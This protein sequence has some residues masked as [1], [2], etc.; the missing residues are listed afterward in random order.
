MPNPTQ[1]HVDLGFDLP[2]AGTI[3]LAVYD[4]AGRR[5]ALLADGW[6]DAGRH[7]VSWN[8]RQGSGGMAQAGVYVVRL[9]ASGDEVV[10]RITRLD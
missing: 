1:G 7:T 5:V 9:E 8:G 10:T 3:R 2:R 6:R 4:L